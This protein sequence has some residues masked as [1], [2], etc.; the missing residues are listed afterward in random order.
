[1]LV[2]LS[3]YSAKNYYLS[4]KV[5]AGTAEILASSSR[6]PA[7]SPSSGAKSSTFCTG[8]PELK[9]LFTST[10]KT[11]LISFQRITLK[12]SFKLYSL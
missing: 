11:E 9:M 1:M 7:S 3:L 8:D 6:K 5:V 12:Y 4:L 2:K 10:F